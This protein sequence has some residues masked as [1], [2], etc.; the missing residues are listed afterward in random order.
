MQRACEAQHRIADF[1]GRLTKFWREIMTAIGVL[2]DK[3]ARAVEQLVYRACCLGTRI[4]A[5]PSKIAVVQ[6]RVDKQRAGGEGT[7]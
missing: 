5:L 6:W 2:D 7:E 3:M 4:D 1:V